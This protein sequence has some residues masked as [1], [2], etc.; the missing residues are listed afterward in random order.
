[1]LGRNWI[2]CAVAIA[3]AAPAVAQQSGPS[4]TVTPEDAAMMQRPA[5]MGMPAPT[6][7]AP[8][9]YSRLYASLDVLWLARDYPTNSLLAQTVVAPP[10]DRNAVPVVGAPVLTLGNLGDG[11]AEPGLRVNLGF[12]VYE[13]MSIELSY[14][15]SQNWNR[16][17]ALLVG[18]P[19]FAN[20]PYL[21]SSI[22]YRNKSFDTAMVG[23]YSSTINNVEAN[24]KD[25]GVF[26]GWTVAGLG[27]LRY[28]NLSEQ[29]TLTGFQTFP[30]FDNP[31]GP[32]PRNQT[33]VEQTRTTTS[34]NLFGVQVG[35]EVGR[36][37]WNDRVGLVMNGK[38]GIF[39]NS[40]NQFTT[41]GANLVT[42][43]SPT[44][45]LASGRGSTDF[46]S[47]YEGGIATTVRVT[48]RI[49]VRGGYQVMFVQGLALAPT[50]LIATGTA[51]QKSFV[52][53]QGSFMPFAPPA[54][55]LPVPGTASTLNTSGN[56]LLHG[57]F[58]GLD[59]NY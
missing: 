52:P 47:L 37:W 11:Q 59:I 24:L 51:I 16:T 9:A 6:T 17:A 23:N 42:G 53:V 19:P 4:F 3:L 38:V 40:A 55:T 56:I 49:R 10:P 13:T 48:S 45:V 54:T 41:N 2:A 26:G 20:S 36:A 33:I 1:M 14:F 57:P 8:P 12:R 58:V 32:P 50:Q 39:A 5:D 27:G 25:T 29:F 21:G 34:N 30:R 15:G 7:V 18:D 35:A 31:P 44:N 46:A 22:I 28:F 43:G